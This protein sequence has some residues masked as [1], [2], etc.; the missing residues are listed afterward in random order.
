MFGTEQV[1]TVM[2]EA[3]ELRLLHRDWPADMR[4]AVCLMPSGE[5]QLML[6]RQEEAGVFPQRLRKHLGLRPEEISIHPPV[7]GFPSRQM[8]YSDERSLEMLLKETPDI[9][10]DAH[11][12]AVNFSYAMEEGLNP[13]T[14]MGVDAMDLD[15][16]EPQDA[17][18]PKAQAPSSLQFASCRQPETPQV[19]KKTSLRNL[20]FDFAREAARA[21]EAA[22]LQLAGQGLVALVKEAAKAKPPAQETAQE[23]T[24]DMDDIDQSAVGALGA[25]FLSASD[26]Q[27]LEQTPDAPAPYVMR[28][29]NGFFEIS[30]GAGAVTEVTDAQSLFLRDDR[31]LLAVRLTGQRQTAPGNMRIAETLLPNAL[32]NV[33]LAALGDVQI[34]TENGYVFVGLTESAAPHQ[35]TLEEVPAK[36]VAFASAKTESA[37]VAK[38]KRPSVL[39]RGLRLFALTAITAGAIFLILGAQP[40]DVLEQKTQNSPID[41]KQFRLSMQSESLG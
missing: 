30:N 37:V 11:D 39:G 9:A 20:H 2:L 25:G 6:F 28:Y 29:E 31:Q 41:W 18:D 10:E 23:P 15:I 1:M 5:C 13:A 33:L 35:N 16:A 17:P 14:F 40:S 36:P 32:R 22:A 27:Q 8:K 24:Q 3:E 4:L 21:P 26:L 12:Y 7:S 34:S 19:V 38:K